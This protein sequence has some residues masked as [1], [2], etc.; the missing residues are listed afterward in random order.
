[1]PFTTHGKRGMALETFSVCVREV[2]AE[3]TKE[4]E[5]PRFQL[6]DLRRTCETMLQ[7]LGTDKEVRA[8]LLSH[9]RSK[10]VQGKHYERYDFL[11]EKRAALEKW[12][13]HLQRII[14]PKREAKVIK[15]HQVVA[16]ETRADYT[17]ERR[18]A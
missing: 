10:G 2:S 13:D 16:R 11:A 8:H 15:L 4:H 9:G 5:Y 12:A 6:R 1:M 14:D 3:L 17:P 18:H 7:K